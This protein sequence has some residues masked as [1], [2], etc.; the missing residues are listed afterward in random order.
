MVSQDE[1]PFSL[2]CSIAI[3]LT[4]ESLGFRASASLVVLERL[5]LQT[6]AL[7]SFCL[8]CATVEYCGLCCAMRPTSGVVISMLPVNCQLAILVGMGIPRPPCCAGSCSEGD[9]N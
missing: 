7:A 9:M 2:A 3:C 5:W 1:A 8:A 6:A 4:F